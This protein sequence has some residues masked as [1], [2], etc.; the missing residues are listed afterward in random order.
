M[1]VVPLHVAETRRRVF[2]V[3]LGYKRYVITCTRCGESSPSACD[4]EMPKLWLVDHIDRHVGKGGAITFNNRRRQVF[5]VPLG[6][7]RYVITCTRCSRSS[8]WG[9]A[10]LASLWFVGHKDCSSSPMQEGQAL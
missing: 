5:G 8:T 1:A 9:D 10:P 4:R 3:P 7:S 2:G 6:R